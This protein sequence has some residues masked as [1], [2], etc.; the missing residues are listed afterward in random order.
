MRGLA[1]ATRQIGGGNDGQSKHKRKQSGL[2]TLEGTLALGYTY[3]DIHD[4]ENDGMHAQRG[5]IDFRYPCSIDVFLVSKSLCFSDAAATR[6]FHSQSSGPDGLCYTL[7]LVD[8]VEVVTRT[9]GLD[10][11]CDEIFT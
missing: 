2:P 8:S 10:Q 4:E 11:C 1:S 5:K 9:T 7:G 3:I 6:D